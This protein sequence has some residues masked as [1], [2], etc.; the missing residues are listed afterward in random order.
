MIYKL[1]IFIQAESMARGQ[2]G[3]SVNKGLTP[4]SYSLFFVWHLKVGLGKMYQYID[5]YKSMF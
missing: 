2:C 4:A 5:I 3:Q 1:M